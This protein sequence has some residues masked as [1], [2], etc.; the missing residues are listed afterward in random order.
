MYVDDNSIKTVLVNL[1]VKTIAYD[2]IPTKLLTLWK[3]REA[4]S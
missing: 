1:F 3:K 2:I 4:N